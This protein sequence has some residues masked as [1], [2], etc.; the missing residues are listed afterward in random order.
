M[1]DEQSVSIVTVDT[2]PKIEFYVLP[3]ILENSNISFAKSRDVHILSPF[4][5]MVILRDRI[6][7]LFGFDYTIECYVPFAKR[8]YGYFVL[9][10]LYGKR[11]IGRMDTKADSK[12]KIFNINNLYFE[13]SSQ[14]SEFILNKFAK[15][16]AIFA[17]F[18]R[19]TTIYNNSKIN[20][21]VLKELI[22]RSN[23][24]IN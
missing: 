10:I 21:P 18:N 3:D 11:F 8:Q 20:Q 1:V 17:L 7:K 19:C 22:K 15:K 6:R 24:Y 4:D 12:T 16:L 14:L 23:E 2:I 13:K 9:P 5:N